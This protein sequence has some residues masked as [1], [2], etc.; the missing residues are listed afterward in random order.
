MTGGGAVRSRAR[1]LAAPL[2]WMAAIYLLSDQ[3]QLPAAPVGWLD[4]AIKKGLHAVGYAVL[5]LLWRRALAGF[6]ASRPGLAAL[7]IAVAYAALDE[8]HQT[9]VPGRQGRLAD[10]AIDAAGALVAL[11]APAFARARRA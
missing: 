2:A 7:A 9:F 4:W 10:V 8:W 6:G 3:P 1:D 5:A 11:C